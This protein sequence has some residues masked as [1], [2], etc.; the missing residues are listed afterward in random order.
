MRII[1][2]S[3]M[4]GISGIRCWEQV[5]DY[6]SLLYKQ[7][8]RLLTAKINACVTPTKPARTLIRQAIHSAWMTAPTS[9]CSNRIDTFI[10]SK[11]E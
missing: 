3:D 9:G 4:D 8:R 5:C 10:Y 7:R 11:G 2:D 6:A 1:K